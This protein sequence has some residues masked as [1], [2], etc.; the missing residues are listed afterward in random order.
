M[1]MQQ[2]KFKYSLIIA[3]LV[4]IAGASCQKVINLKLNN[5]ASQIV[6][7]G[8]LTDQLGSQ[9]VIIS[10]SVPFTNTNVY[11][12]VSGAI[13]TISDTSGDHYA[14]TESPAGTY[15][16]QLLRG[17]YGH[18]YT[19]TV[20]AGGQT[21][22]GTSTMPYPVNLDSVT[23]KVADIGKSSLRTITVNYQDPPDT[24]NQYRFVLYDNSKEAGTIFAFNDAFS[25]GRYVKQDLFEMGTD[26]HALDTAT[27]EMQCIDKP[28]FNYWFSLMQQQQ[29]GPGGGTA[30]SNPPSNLSNNALGYF[31]AHTTQVKS[32][33]VH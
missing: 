2:L 10:K 27:V 26:I 28:I 21:Y 6:I 8:N 17:L 24:V 19:L 32:I 18:I 1:N 14:L 29:N 3:A 22:T 25:D 12:P 9:Y 20:V 11:P 15:S 30:P 13:V 23:A 33:I 7:E 16:I 4:L 5:A 31:S